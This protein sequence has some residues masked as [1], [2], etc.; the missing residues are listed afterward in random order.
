MGKVMALACRMAI[1]A[2]V[3]ASVLTT[4][5]AAPAGAAKPTKPA[6]ARNHTQ[7][8]TWS[9]VPLSSSRDA[10]S[11]SSIH[12]L[13]TPG[14]TVD[15]TAVLT[16]YSD[17]TLQFDVYGS[18]AYNT[19]RLGAFTLNPPNTRKVD[20]GAWI[21]LPVN[22]YDL[23]PKS[24]AEFHFSVNV[25]IDASP[26]DHAGGVVALNL[27]QP[28][29][30][31]PG[32]NLAIQRGEGIAI[33]I[34]VAG[35]LHPG[36]AASD[37]GASTSTPPLGF[38]SSGARVHYAVLNTGNEVLNGTARLE[39]VNLFGSVVKRFAPASIDALIPGQKMVVVEPHWS[40]LPFAGPVHLKVTM[41]TTSVNA[42]GEAEF[43]VVP[44]L[45]VVIILLIIALLVG[46]WW[47]RR[48]KRR[49]AAEPNAPA[50]GLMFAPVAGASPPNAAS[51]EPVT[52]R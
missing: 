48:R 26:G 22:N 6:A 14:Q 8:A 5:E 30:S 3:G 41:L 23:A 50:D 18:D 47:R 2:V 45:L 9:F 4:L 1:V 10:L 21:D 37:I 16:N 15:D 17:Q 32:T 28:A 19:V 35:A 51:D 49:R 20:V 34:R 25:P 44:W 40:G 29:S 24:T 39:A 33:Y 11:Q 27:A 36:V 31:A 42:T 12:L 38:G 46:F 13:A 7:T 43:W 52:T